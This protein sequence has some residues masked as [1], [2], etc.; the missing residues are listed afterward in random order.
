MALMYKAQ[1]S[2]QQLTLGFNLGLHDT[3]EDFEFDYG[4]LTSLLCSTAGT[5][6]ATDLCNTMSR[7][8]MS[9]VA[10]FMSIAL[11]LIGVFSGF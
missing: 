11:A 8:E 7:I 6:C 2:T 10:M 1:L 5:C 4:I 9:F 3:A